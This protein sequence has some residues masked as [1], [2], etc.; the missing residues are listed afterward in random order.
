MPSS[1]VKGMGGLSLRLIR[2]GWPY[3]FF[4]VLAL[5]F[6]LLY[7]V[8]DRGRLVLAKILVDDLLQLEIGS[9]GVPTEATSEM[10]AVLAALLGFAGL[11]R[12]D[13]GLIV[14]ICLAA[15]TFALGMAVFGFLRLYII[16]WASN[17]IVVDLQEQIHAHLLTLHIGFFNVGRVGELMARMTS[18]VMLT[19]RAVR[20]LFGDILLHV[21]LLLGSI[22]AAFYYCWQLA[23]LVLLLAPVM[24]LVLGRFGRQIRRSALKRQGSIAAVSDDL[25]Q[26]LAG[27]RIVK[28]F[29][30][31]AEEE[32]S[33]R[34]RLSSFFKHSMRVSKARILSRSSLEFVSN[35]SVVGLMFVIAWILFDKEIPGLSEGAMAAFLVSVMMMYMPMKILVKAY[36]VFQE[37]LAGGERI[38]EILDRGSDVEDAEGAV[39]L[40]RVREGV[41]YRDVS[42]SYQ[43]GENGR[44]VLHEI[45]FEI[46]RGEV[47]ALVGETGSG[48]S[49]LVDLLFR[50]YDP[51]RGSVEI[52][53]VDLRQIRRASLLRHLA[54]VSQDPFLFN[55]SVRDNIRYGKKDATPAE[56]EGAAKAARIHDL[57]TSLPK[58]YDTVVGERGTSLSGG[59]RQRVTIARAIL[60]DADI[61]ILDEATSSLDSRSEKEVQTAL[62]ALMKDRTTL[63]IAHRLSTIV[64]ANRIVVLQD[65]KVAETGSH[66]ELLECRGIYHHL[67]EIQRMGVKEGPGGPSV[68][69]REG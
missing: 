23:L 66:E 67:F 52:D 53:G 21:F 30:A 29:G 27:I 38:F 63:V 31:E 54:V 4:L 43:G 3:R 40:P 69:R 33:F 36:N 61:L 24:F 65:G 62:E 10:D 9:G 49:T 64:G 28:A 51:D 58:G 1:K 41:A 6:T 50:F 32:E 34:L 22:I 17:R 37:S 56:I 42:F 57:I 46:K 39:D 5:L 2:Y 19:H 11:E 18:D 35:V 44:E 13:W 16:E 59:E 68:E 14:F 12:T 55:A 60:R 20:F 48:K 8:A 45:S 15:G 7:A 47:V 25:Q 26:K